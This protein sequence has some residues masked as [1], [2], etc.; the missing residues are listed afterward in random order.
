MELPPAPLS[1]E[2]RERIEKLEA[3]NQELRTSNE[4]LQGANEELR[5]DLDLLRED[6]DFTDKQVESVMPVKARLS[7]YLDTGFFWVDGDGS[8]IRSDLGHFFF[9]EYRGVLTD[10]WVFMGD[11]LSTMINSRGDPAETSESRA[12]VFDGVDSAGKNSFIVNALNMQLFSG[13]GDHLVLQSS[14]DFI[15]RDRD[16]STD[17][18]AFLGDYVEVKLAYLEYRLRV[19]TS[20]LSIYAGKFDSVV[21][22]EYRVQESSAR[23]TVTP[24][25]ICRY[26]CGRPT[27]VKARLIALDKRLTVAVSVTNGTHFWRSFPFSDEVDSNHFKTGAARIAYAV[28]SL[29]AEIGASGAF[30]SQDQQS[31]IGTYQWHVGGDIHVRKGDSEFT[32]EYVQGKAPGETEMGSAPCGVTQCLEYKGAY[33]MFAYRLTNEL[34]PYARIDWRSAL[35]QA[36]ASFVYITESLRATLGI[37]AEIGTHLIIKGEYTVNREL[38]PV[39]EFNND[40]F[41]SS[42]ILKF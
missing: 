38:D 14:I 21:G 2:W 33:G 23:M 30:G 16:V 42:A 36:G 4:D 5:D 41:A 9:P 17:E 19:E 6:L 11:P 24:S 13:V 31:K 18:G 12:L 3:A 27:G 20:A 35:H 10:S 28:P 39:P 32:G 22:R 26:V 29:G 40:I 15:P 37:R 1:R 25:L 34:I 7:G 8:G